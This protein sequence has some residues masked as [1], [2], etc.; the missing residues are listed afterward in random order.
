MHSQLRW[1][2]CMHLQVLARML[3]RK[4]T[5]KYGSLPEQCTTHRICRV[6]H[7]LQMGKV[8]TV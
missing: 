8:M 6:E 7:F 3:G 2:T 5:Y 4:K 1:L